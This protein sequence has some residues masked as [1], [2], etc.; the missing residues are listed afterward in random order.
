MQSADPNDGKTGLA[1]H[2]KIDLAI[3]ALILL[4]LPSVL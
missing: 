2:N 4:L 1:L 3:L